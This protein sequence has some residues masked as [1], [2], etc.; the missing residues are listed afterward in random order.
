[1]AWGWEGFKL[2]YLLLVTLKPSHPQAFRADRST[3]RCTSTGHHHSADALVGRQQRDHGER[4]RT[5]WRAPFR[6]V[7]DHVETL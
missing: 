7:D 1:M 4:S 5:Q 3:S 2:T 6:L